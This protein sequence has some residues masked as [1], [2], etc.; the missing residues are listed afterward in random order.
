[1]CRV[2]PRVQGCLRWIAGRQGR[3]PQSILG[4]LSRGGFPSRF[5]VGFAALSRVTPSGSRLQDWCGN[6]QTASVESFLDLVQRSGLVEKDRLHALV[7]QLEKIWAGY[8]GRTLTLL[9]FGWSPRILSPPGNA[10]NC[11]RAGIKGSFFSV[12]KLL[13]ELVAGGMSKVYLGEHV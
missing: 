12:N 6:A 3:W 8:L 10:R 5:G 11:W 9:C 13:G 7:V 1:M 4:G 2:A